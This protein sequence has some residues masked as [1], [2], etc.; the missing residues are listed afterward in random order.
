MLVIVDDLAC[1]AF[2]YEAAS[3]TVVACKISLVV[4]KY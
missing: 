1:V 3:Y 4:R 2:T